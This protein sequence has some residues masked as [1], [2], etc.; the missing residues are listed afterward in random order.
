MCVSGSISGPLAGS[1]CPASAGP[2][3]AGSSSVQRLEIT[4]QSLRITVQSAAAHGRH[5]EERMAI[6]GAMDAD[7][8]RRFTKRVPRMVDCC[9][10]PAV[11]LTAA[12]AV[13]AVWFRCRDRLCPLCSTQ[14]SRQVVER[15]MAATAKADSLRFVTLTMR[16]STAPLREQLD[17]LYTCYREF[18]RT[19][20]YKHHVRGG[21]ACVE[22]TRNAATGQ[23]HPHLHVLVDGIYWH[24]RDLSLAWD[25]ATDGS[26]VVDIRAVRGRNAAARYIAKYASKPAEISR[27]PAAAICEY[28]EAV[29]RRRMVISTGTMHGQKVDEDEDVE[30][31]RVI[32]ERVP[33]HAVERRSVMGCDRAMT[34]LACLASQSA[35]YQASLATRRLGTMPRLAPPGSSALRKPADCLR[36]LAQLWTDDPVRF[37]TG[38]DA[39][40]WYGR[41]KPARPPGRGR[42]KD[43]TDVLDPEWTRPPEIR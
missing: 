42:M 11:G 12:G 13:G 7:P 33:L 38:G 4:E 35:A 40:D 5:Q 9:S 32:T 36:E 26:P 25:L 2:N 41:P 20:E 31:K 21:I 19:V 28:A 10:C 18:R 43:S 15:V 34:V 16:S 22:I 17:R 14:R 37:V 23:W 6:V 3:G 27:W 24:Q 29:H 8:A 39:E 30:D 1:S